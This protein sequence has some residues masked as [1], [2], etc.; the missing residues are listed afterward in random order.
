M[1]L[2]PAGGTADETWPR[3]GLAWPVDV[4]CFPV[5]HRP[6]LHRREADTCSGPAL[7]LVE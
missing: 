3:T 2:R 1:V 7:F 5:G 4:R 6:Q